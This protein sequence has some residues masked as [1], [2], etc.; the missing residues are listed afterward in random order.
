MYHW[1]I[2]FQEKIFTCKKVIQLWNFGNFGISEIIP[3]TLVTLRF[4][5][6]SLPQCPE[7]EMNK[8][9]ESPRRYLCRE[10]WHALEVSKI[11]SMNFCVVGSYMIIF[12]K[13]TWIKPLTSWSNFI[14]P[15]IINNIHMYFG[16]KTRLTFTSHL[17]LNL[18]HFCMTLWV[19]KTIF[20]KEIFFF[21]V[22]ISL[23]P[24]FLIRACFLQVVS[25][26]WCLELRAKSIA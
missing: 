21:H 20:Y 8:I 11:Y 12:W 13:R 25:V 7:L 9:F 10:V 4:L 24:N 17:N 2:K 26:Y 15:K 23:R 1:N 19:K 14:L 5:K 18:Q 16:T 3:K 6:V 22:C